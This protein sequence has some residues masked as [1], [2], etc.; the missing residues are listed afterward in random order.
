MATKP[1]VSVLL[2]LLAGVPA[3]AAAADYQLYAPRPAE[4]AQAPPVPGEGVLTK[5]IT[6]QR[7]DTLSGLSHKYS[8]KGSYFPQILLFNRI[9]DPNLIYAGDSLQVPV[10]RAEVAETPAKPAKATK[11][12][13]APKQAKPAKKVA[14]RKSNGKAVARVTTPRSAPAV[15]K[16]APAPAAATDSM[17]QP[18]VA[19]TTGQNHFQRAVTMYKRGEYRQALD[20]FEQFQNRYPDSPLVPDAALYRA[21]CYLKMSEH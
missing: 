4:P 16:Q 21:D 11:A 13:K 9:D 7:G 20:A 8:G 6:I 1:I 15:A 5:T 17:P 10:T 2:M 12:G 18:P 14:S 3:L 19:N